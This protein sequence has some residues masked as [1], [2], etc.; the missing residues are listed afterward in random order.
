MKLRLMALSIPVK[1]FI[2]FK[3]RSCWICQGV[4]R[5]LIIFVTEIALEAE[6]ES[7]MY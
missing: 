5:N 3:V 1:V 6:S 2:G 7:L 4:L